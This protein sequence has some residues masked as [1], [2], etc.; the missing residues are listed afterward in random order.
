MSVYN[1]IKNNIINGNLLLGASSLLD[2]LY[3]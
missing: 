1:L 2:D 3:T